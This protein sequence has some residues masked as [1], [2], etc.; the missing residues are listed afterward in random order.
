[1]SLGHATDTFTLGALIAELDDYARRIEDP[2]DSRVLY[3]FVHFHPK[4]LASYRGDYADL[5]LGYG[6][7][8]SE[9]PKIAGLIEHLKGCV[10]R[11]FHGWKGGIY[12]ASLAT[13][14]WVANPGETGST[15]IV[16]VQVMDGDVV[17]VTKKFV[18]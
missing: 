3:D 8:Y 16:G 18:I 9:A 4:T 11:D 13:P 7:V 1:M 5:A 10:G 2:A 15:G 12:R 17:L 14:V 6:Q